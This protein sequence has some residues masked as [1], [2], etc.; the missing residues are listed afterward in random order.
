MSIWKNVLRLLLY[1]SPQINLFTRRVI[2]C[3][4]QLCRLK[5]RMVN[6]DELVEPATGPCHKRGVSITKL[7][8]RKKYSKQFFGEIQG[9][10]RLD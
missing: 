1:Q 8:N 4:K 5:E 6:Y 10:R 7:T 9:D 2:Y 3:E